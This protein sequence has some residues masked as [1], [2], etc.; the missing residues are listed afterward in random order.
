MLCDSSMLVHVHYVNDILRISD[1]AYAVHTREIDL[2][3]TEY[4]H[5][6]HSI[7][8]FTHMQTNKTQHVLYTYAGMWFIILTNQKHAVHTCHNNNYHCPYT[9]WTRGCV[10]K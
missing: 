9:E 8:H 6:N 10:Y 4:V 3:R 5:D 7:N 2:D 1:C